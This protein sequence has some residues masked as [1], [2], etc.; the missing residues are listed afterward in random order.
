[1]NAPKVLPLRDALPEQKE[2]V[3]KRMTEQDCQPGWPAL[4]IVA[5]SS[6]AED[7]WTLSANGCF[8]LD[9]QMELDVYGFLRLRRP[10][11]WGLHTQ[12]KGRIS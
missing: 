6:A 2:E 12:R 3:L 9:A 8:D 1:M 11:S 7:S 10:F 5:K 4:F